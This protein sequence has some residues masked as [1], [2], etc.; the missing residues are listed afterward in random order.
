METNY[1]TSGADTTGLHKGSGASGSG[2]GSLSGGDIG[3]SSA[4]GSAAG[5]KL[6]RMRDELSTLKSDLDALMSH[7]STLNEQELQ[8]AR[9]RILARFSS[10]RYAAR[11]IAEQIFDRHGR[12]LQTTTIVTRRGAGA[13]VSTA[14]D[15]PNGSDD[16]RLRAPQR[17]RAGQAQC[18]RRCGQVAAGALDGLLYQAILQC[19]ERQAASLQLVVQGIDVGWRTLR[20]FAGGRQGLHPGLDPADGE[21]DHLSGSHR[22]GHCPGQGFHAATRPRPGAGILPCHLCRRSSAFPGTIPG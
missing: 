4:T 19:F 16:D 8:E 6:Y 7:A 22:P 18:A 1:P 11:G 10:M 2:T 20:E 21:P 9:D 13:V 12:C 17:L 15:G 14:S 3:S 5:G